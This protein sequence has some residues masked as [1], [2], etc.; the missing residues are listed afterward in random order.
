MRLY[1]RRMPRVV[2]R[3]STRPGDDQ[4]AAALA[5]R[6]EPRDDFVLEQREADGT[7]S[8][9]HGPFEHYRRTIVPADGRVVETIEFRVAVPYLRWLFGPLMARALRRPPLPPGAPLPWWSPPDRLDRRGSQ[10]LALLALATLAVGYLNTLFTQTVAF[11]ADEFGASKSAQGVAGTVVRCGIVFSVALVVLADRRGRRAML[12][13]AAIAA[14]VLCATG[15][16]APNFA[17]LT[18]T[19]TL[20]RPV[21]ITLGLVI[22]VVAAEEVP[23]NSRAYAAS[24]L[25]LSTGLGAGLCV[26]ALPLADL[27]ERAWRFVY[28]VPIAFLA[29]AWE[30]HRR[31]PESRRFIA[32]HAM[33]PIMDRRRLTLLAGAAFLTNLLVAPASFFGNRYLK[34]VRHYSATRISLYTLV[35]NTPGGVGVMAGGHL[36]DTRGRK[37][38]GAVAVIGGAIFTVATFFAAG[39]PLWVASTLGAVIGGAAVPALGVYG[40]ELFPTGRRGMAAGVISTC[41]LVGS[42]AGLL[43]AGWLLDRDVSYGQVMAL[44]STGPLIVA[45]LVLTRFPETAHADLDDLNP[46]DRL[47]ASSPPVASESEPQATAAS[48]PPPPPP[49]HQRP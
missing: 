38:V 46:E 49:V 14:P 28:V 20:G 19:Q 1:D 36:A 39:A 27:S 45:V 47:A 21:A 16:L 15:A 4:A 9:A 6:F 34:D 22:G 29:I 5:R 41:S 26:M 17:A 33:A 32:P 2:T 42:S 18:A 37:V 7:F 23:R 3:R 13:I 30:V 8:A 31:L 24:V 11:A 12:V 35:T 10:A 40:A 48:R 43:L 25:A 44:L